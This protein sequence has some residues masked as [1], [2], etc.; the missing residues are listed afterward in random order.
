[1][2]NYQQLEEEVLARLEKELDP[3][4]T[5]HSARHTRDVMA[6]TMR[7][8]QAEGVS[9]EDSHLLKVAA[10]LHDAGFLRSFDSHEKHGATLA[11]EMLPGYGYNANQVNT[12]ARLILATQVPQRPQDHLEHIICDADLDYLGRPDF[13]EV[14]GRLYREFLAR[15]IVADFCEWDQIQV[16]F[17]RQHTYFTRTARETRSARKADNLVAIQRR[18][19]LCTPGQ[20][21]PTI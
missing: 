3:V 21:Q 4:L 18:L 8:A 6:S 20:I 19:S 9:E 10:L 11:Q 16:K 2:K 5:Y 7:L 15:N 1:M 13:F 12:I 14:G 17:I